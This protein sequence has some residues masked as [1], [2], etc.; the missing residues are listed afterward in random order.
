MRTLYWLTVALIASPALAP[1]TSAQADP[2]LLLTVEPDRLSLG[3]DGTQ[4][5]AVLLRNAGQTDGVVQLALPTLAGWTF[6]TST[7]QL[8]LA[9]G[10]SQT[11]NVI[12]DAVPTATAS[13]VDGSALFSGTIVQGVTGRGNSAT[14]TVAIAYNA[15]PPP[16]APVVP[17]PN[18]APWIIGAGVLV[19]AGVWLGVWL[20]RSRS[21]D[22]NVRDL[23]KAID[24]GTGGAYP[25]RV[26]NRSRTHRT[27][28]LR[29]THVPARWAAAF[30]FPEVQ[31][32]PRESTTVPVFVRVPS[33]SPTGGVGRVR[34]QARPS[35]FALWLS[36]VELVTTVRDVP[37]ERP[38]APMEPVAT[39]AQGAFDAAFSNRNR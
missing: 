24:R 6:T 37:G 29:I 1:S 34:I 19:V 2:A 21:V 20:A 28:Q 9:A 5:L 25:V 8:N 10:A 26:E 31:L 33:D 12:V 27:V 23:R 11:V 4:T 17:A 35:R 36:S 18:Y 3:P 38:N 22:L 15:P 30:S 14:D 7:R 32:G 16:A 39:S 13:P